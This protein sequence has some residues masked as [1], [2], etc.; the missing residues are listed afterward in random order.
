M[1]EMT[2]TPIYLSGVWGEGPGHMHVLWAEV[3][4]DLA[5]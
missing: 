4:T 5:W 3:P 1:S 2:R